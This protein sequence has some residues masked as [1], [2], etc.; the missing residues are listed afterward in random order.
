[1]RRRRAFTLVELLIVGVIVLVLVAVVA[2]LLRLNRQESRR[3]KNELQLRGIH[4]GLLLFAQ[5]GQDSYVTPSE[6]DK[7]NSTLP[8]DGVASKD[9]P[10]HMMS[11]MIYNG[12]FSPELCV[13]PSESDPQIQ[14]CTA[15]TYNNP[16]AA[17]SPSMALWDPSFRGTPADVP[18]GRDG[19]RGP[20]NL[21]YATMPPVGL[22]RAKWTNSF[23]AT[24][25]PIGNRGPAYVAQGAGACLS[26]LLAPARVK[27]TAPD[28][29]VGLGSHALAHGAPT[30][31]KGFIIYNDNHGVFEQDES[32]ASTPFTFSGLPKGQRS[33]GDNLFVNEDD[34][35]RA[36]CGETL[37]GQAGRN[38]NNFLRLWSGGVQATQPTGGS[39]VWPGPLDAIT[40]WYD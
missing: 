27:G 40:P 23:Q 30:Q 19:V 31:W 18:A 34:A 13:D 4:Q 32:P 3:R 39:W 26:W 9:L 21:S 16:S 1:M 10:G 36:P 15:Y 22:R 20:G 37:A 8:D 5:S 25:A 14:V 2:V 17:V 38:S 12:F 29:P 24:E 11:M 33:Q 6:F 7:A 28:V 35:T